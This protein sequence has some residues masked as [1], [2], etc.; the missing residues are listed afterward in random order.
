MTTRTHA[1]R[2]V[3]DQLCWRAKAVPVR[4]GSALAP[5]WMARRAQGA[6]RVHLGCGRNLLDGWANLDMDGPG[7]VVRFD[8]NR[9]L[10]F[11]SGSVDHVFSEH[12]I[13]HVRLEQATALL[14]ECARILRPG[15]VLRVSTPDLV[16][17]VDEYR[18]GRTDEWTD[19]GWTPETPCDLLNEGMR[20]W[21]HLYVFDE[22]R[23]RAALRDS[24]FRDIVRVAR[25]ESSHEALRG[26]ECR[27]D[28]GDLILEATR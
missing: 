22:S 23:P 21:G 20:L 1:Q 28:H 12:F 26:L 13:E 19:M 10:P 11:P 7:G 4:A 27:P 14:T 9:P 25:H 8:L 17:L 18:A 15:G 5:H 16:R 6:T 3:L 24:R 2:D